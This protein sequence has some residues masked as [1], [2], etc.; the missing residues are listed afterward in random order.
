VAISHTEQVPELLLD[1]PWVESV[2]KIDGLTLLRDRISAL[3]YEDGIELAVRIVD[4]TEF[5]EPGDL[6]DHVERARGAG[7][8]VLVAG[9][10]PLS[11][12]SQLRQSGVSFV[13]PSGVAEISWPRLKVSSGQFARPRERLRA[14]LPMQK[15][16]AVAVQELVVAALRGER[17][18][19]GE[20]AERAG[21]GLSSAS[22]AIS[23]L[24]AHGLVEKQRHGRAVLVDVADPVLVAELLAERTGW[25]Q[26]STLSAFAWGRNIWDVAA[27]VTERARDADISLSVTGRTALAYFGVLGTSSS[28]QVR[29]WVGEQE[30]ELEAVAERLG[31]EPAPI[32]ESNV[33]LAAD[34][35]GVGM[36][37]RTERVFE[38]SRA[39]IAQPIRVW[40]DLH[41]EQRGTEFAAQLWKDIE[42][43][44]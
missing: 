35:W 32:K 33:V 9:A 28:E 41:S 6:L 38:G 11:W 17:L 29:C 22:R 40:C 2:Q 19:V 3:R 21:V 10:V 4:P 12:R 25:P 31:L 13:D 36:V 5:D 34:P 1:L 8:V 26:G 30:S 39:V 42:S 20:V 44:G 7:R 24:E 14:P 18:S 23:Q 43:Y 16:H 27:S 37:G 15:S